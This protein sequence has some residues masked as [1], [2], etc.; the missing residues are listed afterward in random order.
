MEDTKEAVAFEEQR[1][2]EQEA[3]EPKIK[4]K[5]S[6]GFSLDQNQ[7]KEFDKHT[8][9]IDGKKDDDIVDRR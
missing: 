6:V 8:R 9:I 1:E 3:Q 5:K 7:V 4:K 2:V